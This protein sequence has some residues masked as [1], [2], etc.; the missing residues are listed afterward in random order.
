MSTSRRQDRI[1]PPTA[2]SHEERRPEQVQSKDYPACKSTSVERP[3]LFRSPP[4]PG[5]GIDKDATR[6]RSLGLAPTGKRRLST[7]HTRNGTS[8][9]RTRPFPNWSEITMRS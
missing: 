5:D 9:K 3:D 8:V 6:S 4:L 7:A 2:L 1:W